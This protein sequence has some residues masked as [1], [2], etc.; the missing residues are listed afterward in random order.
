MKKLAT[1]LMAA[2]LSLSA[3][4]TNYTG[5]LSVDV[6]G[7]GSS[8]ATTITL[9]KN[10]D[11]TYNF[12]LKNFV[13]EADGEK[14]GVGNIE[15][16]NLKGTT[17]H[18]F[19][20]VQYADSVTITNGDDPTITT[21]LGPL[22]GKVPVDLIAKFNDTALVVSITIDMKSTLGQEID[23]DFVGSAPATETGDL[24]GDGKI[25]VEDVTELVNRILAGQ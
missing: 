24:N 14:M 20:T 17:A 6:N 22:L 12:V 19:T 4:A 10:T 21:W 23:V 8:Q 15:L 16:N 11:G 1:L 18:G 9:E 2:L 7:A 13:L 3:W 25:N 5:E